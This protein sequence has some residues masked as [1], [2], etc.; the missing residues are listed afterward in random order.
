MREGDARTGKACAMRYRLQ[1]AVAQV[2]GGVLGA[3]EGLR[4]GSGEYPHLRQEA[5]VKSGAPITVGWG[6]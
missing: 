3:L 1:G 4:I 5:V 6:L 2:L